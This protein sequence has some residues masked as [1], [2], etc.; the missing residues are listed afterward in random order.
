VQSFNVTILGNGAASPTLERGPSAQVVELAGRLFLVDCG[1]GVQLQLRKNKFSIQKIN[2]ILITHLHG[3]HYLGLLGLLQ[4]MHLLGRRTPINIYA[5]AALKDI[6]DLQNKVSESYLSFEIIYS[7]HSAQG[8]QLVFEDNLMEVYTF[9]LNHRIP[10]NG[11][12]FKEK[13]LLRKIDKTLLNEFDVDVSEIHKL[14]KG[15]NVKDKIG[16]L[17]PYESVTLP[18]REAKSYAI[19]TDTVFDPSLK[20]YIDGVNGLYH[21]A[22]FLHAMVD[23]AKKTYHTTAQQAAQMALLA[24][25]HKLIIGHFSARYGNLNEF[26]EEAKTIFPS[27]F[28]AKEGEVYQI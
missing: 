4:S 6:I 23:R 10:C 21:E 9:P 18:S 26:L 1:E 3:D 11:V 15:L 7:F 16:N 28:I 20:Q 8:L 12:L 27:T 14:K 25:A 2:H 5:H 13:P 24:N 19:C 22:T 17:V